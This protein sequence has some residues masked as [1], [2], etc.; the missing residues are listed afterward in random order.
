MSMS[1]RLRDMKSY[2]GISFG[3]TTPSFLNN[4]LAVLRLTLFIAPFSCN[5][6]CSRSVRSPGR[7]GPCPSLLLAADRCA[8]VM[9]VA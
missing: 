3:N 9:A 8:Q 2:K 1:T 6:L 5:V 4:A 7:N